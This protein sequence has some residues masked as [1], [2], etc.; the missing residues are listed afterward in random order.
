MSPQIAPFLSLYNKQVYFSACWMGIYL[1]PF[2]ATPSIWRGGSCH[3]RNGSNDPTNML[4][5]GRENLGIFKMSRL[6][7]DI[8]DQQ[9]QSLEAIAVELKSLLQ[10]RIEAGL[11]GKVSAKSIGKI[12]DEELATGDRV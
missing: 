12:L 4:N 6:V 8:T 9:R 1:C 7:I 5:L 10:D 2:D 11:T 3:R